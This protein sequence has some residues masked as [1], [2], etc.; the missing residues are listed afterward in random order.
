MARFATLK[1]CGEILARY[2]EVAAH[3]W[4][5]RKLNPQ[6]DYARGEAQFLPAAL[7]LQETPPPAAPRVAMWLIMS[8][9]AIALTWAI[10]GQ[11]DI[12]A[13]APGKVVPDDRSK[14]IQ[15][16]ET[17]TVTAIH[18]TDGQAVK[19][20]DKLIEL[21]ATLATAERDKLAGEL[22]LARLQ[23][24]R[25]E[26]LLDAL[27][28]GAVPALANIPGVAPEREAE[29]RRQLQGQVEEYLAKRARF[30]AEIDRRQAEIETARKL[31]ARLEQTAPIAARR[32][33][34]YKDLMEKNFISQH[35]YLER[36]QTRIEQESELALQKNR[37]N[38]LEAAL[39]ESRNQSAAYT[40]ELRRVTLESIQDGQQKIAAA[41][42][43]HL[44]AD[45]RSRQMTLTAPV[46]G[47]VQQLATHTIGGVVTPAQPIMVVVPSQ[48]SVEIE[49]LL[50]NR[51]IAFVRPG[52][53]AEIKID[54]FPYTKY[55]TLPGRVVTVSRDAAQDEKRGLV[56]PVVIKLE[57][58]AIRVDDKDI[59]ITPGMAVSA[60]IKTGKRRVIE[61]FLSPLME[62]S[63]E[64]LRER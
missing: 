32:A 8:L 62:Y 52:Q 53:L 51:D 26:A 47:V 36:E 19:A 60:E 20:G 31:V 50:E 43:D 7:A 40:A 59:R 55:G 22:G 49:A 48:A 4:R 9:A 33:A 21:D 25:G 37:I 3:A 56:F 38:E 14:L 46:D 5:N 24:A 35:G 23:V 16:V 29:A 64:S 61:Y 39:R 45:S 12:V 44:K 27:R 11:I 30:Q 54:A 41:T 10:L 18:V 42:Q 6:P 58:T 57:R 15:S 2:R 13:S 34:D 1:A 63:S 28:G 17:A